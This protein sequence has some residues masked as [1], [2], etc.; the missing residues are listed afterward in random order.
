MLSMLNNLTETTGLEVGPSPHGEPIPAPPIN[1]HAPGLD[2][3]ASAF[4]QVLANLTT[5]PDKTSETSAIEESLP[6]D[7]SRHPLPVTG[8]ALPPSRFVQPEPPPVTGTPALKPHSTAVGLGI[9]VPKPQTSASTGIKQGTSGE[10]GIANH[11]LEPHHTKFSGEN[12]ADT[13]NGTATGVRGLHTSVLA[14]Q[15][16]SAA[17]SAEHGSIVP[18]DKQDPH[19]RTAPELQAQTLKP[20]APTAMRQGVT[21]LAGPRH[22]LQPALRNASLDS[23]VSKESLDGAFLD[24]VTDTALER[25]SD[26][27]DSVRERAGATA[28]RSALAAGTEPEPQLAEQVL[29]HVA[30]KASRKALGTAVEL[31]L[32]PREL[33]T[34]QVRVEQMPEGQ[35]IVLSGAE[36]QT[37]ELLESQLPRLRNLMANA[38][39]ESV[40]VFI[41]HHDGDRREGSR[42][43]TNTSQARLTESDEDSTADVAGDTTLTTPPRYHPGAL[44]AYA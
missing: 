11:L 12:R 26:K 38:G 14:A 16:P 2:A 34:V 28:F 15:P 30:K 23:A 8:T 41:A 6:A 1:Q 35:R 29:A 4:R 27:A 42:H 5:A 13:F 33:G 21:L 40:E 31:Q 3:S 25:A 9:S 22:G 43:S 36:A 44:S 20:L 32:H 19:G 7:E 39:L 24:A 10:S 37:R 18:A 17:D